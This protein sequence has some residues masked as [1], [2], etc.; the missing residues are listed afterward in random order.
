MASGDCAVVAAAFGAVPAIANLGA[1]GVGCCGTSTGTNQ[2]VE[3]IIRCTGDGAH[4]RNLYVRGYQT[5]GAFPADLTQL[6]YL[7]TLDLSNM[8]LTGSLPTGWASVTGLQTFKIAGNQLTGTLPSDLGVLGQLQDIEV[9]SNMFIG[10]IPDFTMATLQTADFS[11]NCF[12][13]GATAKVT[14]E[15]VNLGGQRTDCPA[16]GTTANP[17]AG[18]SETAGAFSPSSAND[19]GSGN[20]NSGQTGSSISIIGRP[21]GSSSGAVVVSNRTTNSSNGSNAGNA[22]VPL[23]SPTSTDSTTSTSSAGPSTGLIAGLG[24]LGIVVIAALVFVGIVFVRRQSKGDN[25]RK[26]TAMD[27]EPPSS[28]AGISAVP[29]FHSSSIKKPAVVYNGQHAG[30]T[31]SYGPGAGND[32]ATSDRTHSAWNAETVEMHPVRYWN[33]DNGTGSTNRLGG[34][35]SSGNSGGYNGT[36]VYPTAGDEKRALNSAEEE[37]ARWE[38]HQQHQ[39]DGGGIFGGLYALAAHHR[40]G[41]GAS[42]SSASHQP[43]KAEAARASMY[44][45]GRGMGTD[46]LPQYTPYQ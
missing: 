43:S 7:T 34:G 37:R 15:T 10:K 28:S 13:G 12:E 46:Q 25:K 41:D 4:I 14:A 20:S 24:V 11:D 36:G 17:A 21:T 26:F 5:G 2:A 42:S 6:T 38:V 9:D 23:A 39:A 40:A 3:T 1:G 45:D 22:N 30:F 35:S 19:G 32:G 29:A 31:V 27:D 8:G 44:S 16:L 18:P 33:D